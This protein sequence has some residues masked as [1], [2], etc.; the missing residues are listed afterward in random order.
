MILDKRFYN[1]FSF[2][3][4]WWIQRQMKRFEGEKVFK[5][6]KLTKVI[7]PSQLYFYSNRLKTLPVYTGNKNALSNWKEAKLCEIM[8]PT[9]AIKINQEDIIIDPSGCFCCGECIRI[10][11]EGLLSCEGEKKE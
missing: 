6:F 10:A 9:Q 11:P 1:R 7:F 5:M 8:C 2:I 4:A 3:K